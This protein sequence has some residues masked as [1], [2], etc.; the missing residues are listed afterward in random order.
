MAQRLPPGH[1][2]RKCRLRDR[3]QA[4]IKRRI[5]PAGGKELT[6]RACDCCVVGTKRARQLAAHSRRQ[7]AA[8][9]AA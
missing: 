2:A 4:C 6:I 8:P 7:N 3:E 5:F 1:A 9:F